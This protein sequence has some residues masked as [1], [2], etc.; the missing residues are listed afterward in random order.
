MFLEISQ[1]SQENTCARVSF[2]TKFVFLCFPMNFAKFLVTPLLTEHL[3]WVLLQAKTWCLISSQISFYNKNFFWEDHNLQTYCVNF[4]TIL[5]TERRLYSKYIFIFLQIWTL[6][7]RSSHH[8]C[9]ARIG[10]LR[11]FAT[12]TGKH[13]CL[14]LFFSR[15][16]K[17]APHVLIWLLEYSVQTYH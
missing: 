15:S 14:S 2:S 12:F 4:L 8:S 13:L 6:I 11:N 5:N 1:N 16:H 17:K 9:S 10:V 3:R 7:F